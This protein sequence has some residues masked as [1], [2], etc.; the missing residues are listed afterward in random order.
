[1]KR[2]ILS[3][4]AVFT[5]AAVVVGCGSSNTALSGNTELEGTW[6]ATAPDN[7]STT[8]FT[9][10]GDDCTFTRPG[11]LQM[12]GTFNLS[13]AASP[14]TIDFYIATSSDPQ[15]VGK[16][17]LGIYLLSGT[18]LT[19]EIGMPGDARPASFTE[20]GFNLVKQ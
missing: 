18:N 16:T 8:T 1:M 6:T 5:I 10:S 9:F 19:L 14:K 20:D 3:V 13:Y 12:S 4:L 15:Y 17:S 11:V 2:L 7:T